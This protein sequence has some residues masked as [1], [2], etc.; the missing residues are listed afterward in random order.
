MIL[1]CRSPKER[2]ELTFKFGSGTGRLELL[3]RSAL[4]DSGGRTGCSI[5]LTGSCAWGHLVCFFRPNA[6]LQSTSEWSLQVGKQKWKLENFGFDSPFVG[7]RGNFGEGTVKGRSCWWFLPSVG[8][9][10]SNSYC[11]RVH[12]RKPTKAMQCSQNFELKAPQFSGLDGWLVLVFSLTGGRL[13]WWSL[14]LVDQSFSLDLIS[15]SRTDSRI[16]RN[17]K[18][19]HACAKLLISDEFEIMLLVGLFCTLYFVQLVHGFFP[20]RCSRVA[21]R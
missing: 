4:Y 13:I 20:F 16:S 2:W 3:L 5:V 15:W 19:Q 7:A 1:A 12:W 8:L 6:W 10:R 18:S 21:T 9:P 14:V 11:T 17:I